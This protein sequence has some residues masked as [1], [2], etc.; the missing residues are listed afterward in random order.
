MDFQLT[1][2]FKE[3]IQREISNIS[4]LLRRFQST[5]KYSAS[6]TLTGGFPIEMK[7]TWI[8]YP[9][10]RTTTHQAPLPLATDPSL[11]KKERCD[12]LPVAT[13]PEH[14]LGSL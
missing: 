9:Y 13:G 1:I 6:Y 11:K 4:F 2:V 14:M 8:S 7:G 12:W 10:L 3:K 5:S